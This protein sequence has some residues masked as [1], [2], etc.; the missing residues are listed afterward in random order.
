[1]H[2]ERLYF[3]GNVLPFDPFTVM[4]GLRLPGSIKE[5]VSLAPLLLLALRHRRRHDPDNFA[6]TAWI[7]RHD[8]AAYLRKRAPHL[9]DHA[10]EPLMQY[11]TLASGD[12]GL[13]W[14]VFALAD[15]GWMRGWWVYEERGAGGVTYELGRVLSQDDG[16]D[17]RLGSTV[18]G[19]ERH[20]RKLRVT[21]I[22]NG[23]AATI[24]TD[25]VIMA[26][27]GNAVAK[28]V[29]SLLDRDRLSFFHGI[30]Y[31]AHHLA[32]YHVDA[33]LSNMPRKVLLPGV[34]GFERVAKVSVQTLGAA[35][36]VVTADLKHSFARQIRADHQHEQALT[37]AWTEV[38]R[39][40]PR[41]GSVTVTD[42]ILTRNDTALCRRPVGF[43]TRLSDFIALPPVDRL[44]F[45][46]DYL[47]NSTVGCAHL[48]GLKAAHQLLAQRSP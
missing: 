33:S 29:G 5:K 1:V 43:A 34:E 39:A 19:I 44:A 2:G 16:C 11:S 36:A 7:D 37:E 3:E 35:S 4:G 17:L 8:G 27:P 10:I 13:A 42:R 46:G 32:R 25:A 6:T 48:T 30:S 15:L 21:A 26:V 18:R 28:I 24:T 41:L 47:L 9:F 38:V 31:V 45:A 14:L 22:V 40:F 23:T 20:G 12:Y